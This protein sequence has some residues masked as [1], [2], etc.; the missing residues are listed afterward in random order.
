MTGYFI[1]FEGGE[2]AGKTTQINRL[3]KALTDLK[4]QVVTTR[5]PGG[6]DEGD[7]IRNLLVQK[8]G[9]GWDA[10]SECLLL[11]AARRMHLDKVILP[12]L[13]DGM[14]VISD[15]FTDSTLAYQGYGHG[16]A[17]EK[18]AALSKLSIDD[19]KP[20]RTFILDIDPTQGLD[21]SERRLASE[22][23]K[24]N[25]SEDK[26]EGLELTFHERLRKGFLDIAK[27][28]PLRC[29]VLDASQTQDEIATQILNATLKDLG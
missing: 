4:H 25:Q 1:T 9:G 27:K 13:E 10:M 5:E 23:L 29:I 7:K 2:G 14:I 26:Y 17:L 6:T 8:D 28:E 18:I 15:R 21:R 11:F 22:S 3:A 12:A 24:I 19:F 20:Q 16:L